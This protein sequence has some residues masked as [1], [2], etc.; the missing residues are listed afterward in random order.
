MAD[1]PTN[2]NSGAATEGHHRGCH[3]WSLSGGA[4]VIAEPYTDA[5]VAAT[6][7]PPQSVSGLAEGSNVDTIGLAAV[8]QFND[9]YAVVDAMVR[10]A[11]AMGW[12]NV[13]AETSDKAVVVAFEKV[14]M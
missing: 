7:P 14:Q 4:I 10:A 12:R 9:Q 13:Y 6:T 11:R 3:C 5:V 2:E 8:D 1:D